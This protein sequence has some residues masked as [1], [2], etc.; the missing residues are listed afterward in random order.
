MKLDLQLKLRQTIAPQLIQSLKMLQ[1]PIL[2]LEQLVRQE[3]STNPMLEEVDTA[4]EAEISAPESSEDNQD[5]QLE[6]IDWQEFLGEDHEC[7][8]SRLPRDRE[9]FPERAVVLEET[10]YEHLLEQLHLSRLAASEKEIAEYII[11]NIDESGFLTISAREISLALDAP[12]AEVLKVLAVVQKFDPVG[13][14]AR[15]LKECLLIQLQEKGLKGNLAYRIVAEHL[16]Q[17]DKKSQQQLSRILGVSPAKVEQA[18]ETIRS[19]NPCPAQGGFS[20]AAIPVVP[21][22][23]VERL[24]DEFVVFHNDRNVPH[25]RVNTAYRELLKQGKSSEDTKK[26]IREKLEQA[27]WLVNAINQRRTT[28]GRVMEAIVEKQGDFFESGPEHLKPM[29]MESIAEKVGMNVATISRVASGKYVQTP[30]GVFEIRYF[31]NSG[32]TTDDGEELTKRAI[33]RRLEEI[34]KN[35]NQRRPL[36]DQEI[37]DLLKKEGLSIARRTVTKYREELGIMPARFRKKVRLQPRE[38][39]KISGTE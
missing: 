37:A 30:M 32:M 25:L 6:K 38:E 36:S 19:L 31:F 20:K 29:T 7:N 39:G 15:D 34:I 17:L 13:V 24:G 5:P 27:R 8:Y 21:D 1:M 11:G 23:T 16:G 35:E 12:E 9:E 22:L 10:L 26:Y 4:E 33:K 28:M 18:M 14:G 2:R 3:L